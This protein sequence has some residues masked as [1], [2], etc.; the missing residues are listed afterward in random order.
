MIADNL[1][2]E[3]SFFFCLYSLSNYK[4]TYSLFSLHKLLPLRFNS[5]LGDS[6]SRFSQ[7][8]FVESGKERKK[9]REEEERWRRRKEEEGFH[10]HTQK[11]DEWM[12]GLIFFFF[13]PPSSQSTEQIANI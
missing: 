11:K 3:D 6:L 12:S 5:L 7:W 4:Q 10:T 1:P 8:L 2:R 13:L 9:E